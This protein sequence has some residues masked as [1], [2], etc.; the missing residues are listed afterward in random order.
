MRHFQI[1]PLCPQNRY[2]NHKSGLKRCFLY[3]VVSPVEFRKLVVLCLLEVIFSLHLARQYW[4][5]SSS[6][7]RMHTGCFYWSEKYLKGTFFSFESLGNFF[8]SFSAAKREHS[9]NATSAL[10]FPDSWNCSGLAAM[11]CKRTA[12]VHEYR[13]FSTSCSWKW[14]F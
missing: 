10:L 1:L 3:W 8:C 14:G 13:K 11:C 9:W 2:I 7:E 12:Y 5:S 6:F 4:N